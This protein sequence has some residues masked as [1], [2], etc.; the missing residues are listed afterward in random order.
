[1]KRNK[2][3]L[4]LC[5]LVLALTLFASDEMYLWGTRL[6]QHPNRSRCQAR[7]AAT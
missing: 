5:A 7:K 4:A 1:M 6:S 3:L 2:F